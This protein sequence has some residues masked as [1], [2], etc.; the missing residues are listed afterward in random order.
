MIVVQAK[1]YKAGTRKF[2][3]SPSE[4]PQVSGP[5][6]GITGPLEGV[7]SAVSEARLDAGLCCFWALKSAPLPDGP[8][9]SMTLP[10]CRSANGQQS[11]QHGGH[12]VRLCPGRGGCPSRKA[13]KA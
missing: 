4:V 1:A 11:K 13:A 6:P 12:H 2:R 8:S 10:G 7:Q 9:K 3:K 5:D